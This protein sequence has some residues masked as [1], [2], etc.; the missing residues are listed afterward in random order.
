M[1]RARFEAKVVRGGSGECWPWLGALT[2]HGHG[3]YWLTRRT[4]AGLDGQ[5]HRQDLVVIA[6][7]FGYALAHGVEVLAAAAVLA[8][9]CDEPWCQNPAHV[10]P[11]THGQNHHDWSTRRWH[12]R[13]PLRDTRGQHGRALAVRAAARTGGDI[14]AAKAAG[15]SNLDHD[16]LVLW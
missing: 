16:Q 15:V 10:E 8:H 7:R 3:R 11:S 6:H 1:V 2:S 4:L 14:G 12:P 9:A 5:A 13:S